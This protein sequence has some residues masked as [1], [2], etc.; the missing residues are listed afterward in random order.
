MTVQSPHESVALVNA[1]LG[2]GGPQVD[3]EVASGHVQAIRPAHSSPSREGVE[4][5]GCRGAILMPG[6][7]DAHVHMSQLASARRRVDLTEATSARHAAAI[8]TR[9]HDTGPKTERGDV[10]FGYGFRDGLWSDAPTDRALEQVLPLGSPWCC[11]AM[12]C[13]QRG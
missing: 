4:R 7:E 5:F 3:V 10:L 1:T 13:T 6:L 8:V 12:T 2:V 9:A 11:K